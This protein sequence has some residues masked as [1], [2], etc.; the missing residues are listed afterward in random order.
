MRSDPNSANREKLTESSYA[1]GLK[2]GLTRGWSMRGPGNMGFVLGFASSWRSYLRSLPD[3][4]LCRLC[5]AILFLKPHA[6]RSSV[7]SPHTMVRLIRHFRDK[8]TDSFD[9]KAAAEYASG[10]TLSYTI[11]TES[12]ERNSGHSWGRGGTQRVPVRCR[13]R[14]FERMTGTVCIGFIRHIPVVLARGA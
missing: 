3:S 9:Q 7:I 14:C 12:G 5:G 11:G 6:G 13:G 8:K 2:R 1:G 10:S 4:I